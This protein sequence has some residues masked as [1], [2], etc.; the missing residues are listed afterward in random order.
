LKGIKIVVITVAITI[1]IISMILTNGYFHSTLD[2]IKDNKQL[3]T[4][5]ANK[6]QSESSI[7]H[8]HYSLNLS[9]TSS[10]ESHMSK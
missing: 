1:V 4:S 6:S 3:S 2:A 5:L 10:T 8:K 7:L 9:D